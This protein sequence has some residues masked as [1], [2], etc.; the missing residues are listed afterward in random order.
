MCQRMEKSCATK[1]SY[2][3]L[4]TCFCIHSFSPSYLRAAVAIR[5]LVRFVFVHSTVHKIRICMFIHSF[6]TSD[7]FNSMCFF[8]LLYWFSNNGLKRPETE[9]YKKTTSSFGRH[10]FK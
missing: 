4:L 2:Q 5:L 6:S 3:M 10:A 7:A 9:L 8:H 1:L